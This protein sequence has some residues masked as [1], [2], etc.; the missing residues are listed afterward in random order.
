MAEDK[1]IESVVNT[2]KE[3][4]KLQEEFELAKELYEDINNA[5]DGLF[6]LEW[7]L[8][9]YIEHLDN[10]YTKHCGSDLCFEL[11]VKDYT[12]LAQLALKDIEEKRTILQV[13]FDNILEPYGNRRSKLNDAML[14]E[15]E[16]DI[17]PI[18]I[19][20]DDDKLDF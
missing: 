16:W 18:E 14:T 17:D 9:R 20:K 11:S 7:N 10:I 6:K 15:V 19:N 13:L 4:E 12:K 2:D 3:L 8:L 1:I 5:K